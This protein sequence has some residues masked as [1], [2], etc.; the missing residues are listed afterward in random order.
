MPDSLSLTDGHWKLIQPGKGPKVNINTNTEMGNDA[1]PQLYNLAN[2]RG[3][4]VNVAAKYPERV[5]AMMRSIEK[6]RADGRSRP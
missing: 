3:E 1:E 4:K 2:D 6:I 5:A